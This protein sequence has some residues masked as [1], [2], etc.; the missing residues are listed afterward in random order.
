MTVQRILVACTL[1]TN[2]RNLTIALQNSN[3]IQLQSGRS[4]SASLP[5]R[6]AVFQGSP[7]LPILFNICTDIV[8]QRYRY[9]NGDGV[10]VS[11]SGNR[12]SS[13]S[14]GICRRFYRYRKNARCRKYRK[15]AIE[16]FA[17]IGSKVNPAKSKA[18]VIANGLE[19]EEPL[20]LSKSKRHT[21]CKKKGGKYVIRGRLFLMG[22]TST[23]TE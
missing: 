2:N 12:E 14:F 20:L 18:V 15:T 23:L 3:Q 1:P 6:I 22:L 7:L 21:S 9:N 5:V 17:E 13:Q 16:L 8:T 4:K 11:F 10:R 19:T